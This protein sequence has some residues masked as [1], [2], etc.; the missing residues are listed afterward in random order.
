MTSRRDRTVTILRAMAH[1]SKTERI[2]F[3]AGSIAYNAFLSLLP[4]LFLLIAVAAA[5]GGSEL[6]A[7]VIG[8]TRSVATPGAGDVIVTELQNASTGASVLGVVLLA[9]GM[10]RIFRNL[11]TAFSNIYETESENTITDQVR[12][13]I[14]VFG[15]IAA[16]I[17]GVAALESVVSISNVS[18]PLIVL[19]RLFLVP[20]VMAA[21]FPMY[22]LFPDEPEMR[23]LEVVPGV[24]V[25]ASALIIFQ[26]LFRLYVQYSSQTAENGLLASVLILLTWLYFSGLVLL[27]GV[28]VNAVLSNR[29]EDVN[30][31]PLFGGVPKREPV[32]TQG[33]GTMTVPEETLARLQDALKTATAVHVSF[34][35]VDDDLDLPP[36]DIVT[37]DT[38]TSPLPSVND[39]ASLQVR[40]TQDTHLPSEGDD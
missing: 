17:V 29:S 25:V 1:E 39:T 9:W 37:V 14:V 18:G 38:N 7:S 24:F 5:V 3:M 31:E 22:Y 19:Q 32:V 12:D 27:V 33:E 23:P 13:G 35:G 40:W 21:L 4:F 11:D 16:V 36:P 30:I 10:L 20:V 34:D 15:S 6:E 28:V 2:T 26:S 8:L